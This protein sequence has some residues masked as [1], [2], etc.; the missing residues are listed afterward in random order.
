MA[1]EINGQFI[2]DFTSIRFPFFLSFVR[3]SSLPKAAAEFA[4][5][6]AAAAA[7]LLPLPPF[8][9]IASQTTNNK[10]VKRFRF[11]LGIYSSN[12]HKK[13]KTSISFFQV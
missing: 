6:K 2:R 1:N 10:W 11:Q 8:Q 13:A 9:L 3:A 5:A 7:D 4:L 12:R